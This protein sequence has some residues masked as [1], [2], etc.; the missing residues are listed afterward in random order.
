MQS[1]VKQFS[2]QF[3]RA[4][5]ALIFI[6]E[7]LAG[8]FWP[9]L[10]LGEIPSKQTTQNQNKITCS[11]AEK[12]SIV[13]SY[14]TVL[15]EEPDLKIVNLTCIALKKKKRVVVTES[16]VNYIK[17]IL[18]KNDDLRLKAGINAFK[19]IFSTYPDEEQI[20][21]LNQIVFEG[22]VYSYSELKVLLDTNK[23]RFYAIAKNNKSTSDKDLEISK[24]EN[25]QQPHLEK[26]NKALTEGIGGRLINSGF[27]TNIDIL[28]T[29]ENLITS[30]RDGSLAYL[31]N[32][33][34]IDAGYG[35][36]TKDAS[37]IG[38]IDNNTISAVARFRGANDFSLI[39][40]ITPGQINIR[41][42]SITPQVASN[43]FTTSFSFA[44]QKVETTPNGP[45]FNIFTPIQQNDNTTSPFGIVSKLDGA[46][47]TSEEISATT[48]SIFKLNKKN[49]IISFTPLPD[50]PTKLISL[51]NGKGESGNDIEA[52][53]IIK[54]TSGS[55]QTSLDEQNLFNIT[56]KINNDL[57][58]HNT[59]DIPAKTIR[60]ESVEKFKNI[61]IGTLAFIHDRTEDL[62]KIAGS[63]IDPSLDAFMGFSLFD[64]NET[65]DM[66]H[67][68]YHYF[69]TKDPDINN[70][71]NFVR[72]PI[73]GLNPP[74]SNAPFKGDEYISG[75]KT[76]V[77]PASPKG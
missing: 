18:E 56:D 47:V 38:S 55:Y 30:I 21:L 2:K 63:V 11:I 75:I 8:Y 40:Q 28:P 77:D 64:Y 53:G 39:S 50:D 32:I 27:C 4:V 41:D 69:G 52:L 67:K 76:I 46:N 31:E 62:Q 43:A 66:F 44:K 57:I 20:K 17:S 14:N 9:A 37:D 10:A 33:I 36:V 24:N 34:D 72:K 5:V 45:R 23:D 73:T 54:N 48:S 51:I 74:N 22:P 60:T 6:F 58:I 42:I 68:V 13:Y 59:I 70:S 71:N 61:T 29:T 35:L 15:G 65:T 3:L 49:N 7:I 26:N 16:V 25:T 19:S 12:Y 1:E